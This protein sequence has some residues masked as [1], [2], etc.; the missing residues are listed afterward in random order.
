LPA[1]ERH[2]QTQTQIMKSNLLNSLKAGTIG[3]ALFTLAV[4]SARAGVE[5]TIAK[6][7]KVQSG[8]QLVV[9]ADRGSIEIKTS[10]GGVVNIEMARKAGGSQAQ[11][12]KTLQDHVVTITQDGNKVEVRAE[13][14]GQKLSGWFGNSP[15]LQVKYLITIPRKFDVDLKT[16]GGSIKAADLTGSVQARTS[17]GSLNFAKVEGPLSGH[18]SGGS[19][20]V[21]GCKGNADLKTSGG[22]IHLCDVE[23]DV[24]ARTS[25]GWIRADKLTGK[26]ILKDRKSV[27]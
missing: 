17:G 18:T 9:A 1:T 26:S 7:F 23:G 3:V 14:K 4:A 15:Q 6:S 12:Q 21:A 16:S 2:C 5:D 19:I 25:G 20:T 27:V 10:D 22:S 8:G 11:A 24:D 13:Y